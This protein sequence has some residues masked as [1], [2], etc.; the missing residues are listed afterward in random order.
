MAGILNDMIVLKE[1]STRCIPLL[2]SDP[3]LLKCGFN[4]ASIVLNDVEYDQVANRKLVVL[5]PCGNLNSYIGEILRELLAEKEGI[6]AHVIFH[7]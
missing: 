3:L 6:D 4:V 2:S 1:A 7:Y 5:E